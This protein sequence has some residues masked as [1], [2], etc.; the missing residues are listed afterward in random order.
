MGIVSSRRRPRESYHSAFADIQYGISSFIFIPAIPSVAPH[1]ALSGQPQHTYPPEPADP[2]R[3]IDE[4]QGGYGEVIRK[5]ME[6][7]KESLAWMFNNIIRTPYLQIP[8]SLPTVRRRPASVNRCVETSKDDVSHLY[9][10]DE[11]FTE[12]SMSQNASFTS[13]T[14]DPFTHDVSVRSWE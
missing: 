5:V 12:G 10:M 4:G 6:P 7:I 3:L 8:R 14:E 13:W 9:Y 1:S 2:L 11:G